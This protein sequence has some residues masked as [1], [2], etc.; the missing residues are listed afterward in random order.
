MSFCVY[1][2]LHDITHMTKSPRPSI[3]ASISSP[4][5]DIAIEMSVSSS[6]DVMWC[7]VMSCDVMWCHFVSTQHYMI[8]LTWLNLPDLP[9]LQVFTHWKRLNSDAMA[10]QQYSWS[11][12]LHTHSIRWLK[13]LDER[14][15]WLPK[16]F[17]CLGWYVSGILVKLHPHMYIWNNNHWTIFPWKKAGLDI[18]QSHSLH[19]THSAN[20]RPHQLG[21]GGCYL[22][23]LFCSSLREGRIVSGTVW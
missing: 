3:S 19:R 16:S 13:H 23:K 6:C 20:T 14:C 21:D 8:S 10:N 1:P 5:I 17:W 15:Y 4:W 12:D 22:M 9:S 7:H 18:K 2:T 11:L